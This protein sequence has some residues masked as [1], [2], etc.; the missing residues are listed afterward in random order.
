M[1][2]SS[3]NTYSAGVKGNKIGA[4]NYIQKLQKQL[5]NLSLKVGTELNMKKDNIAGAVTINPKLLEKMQNNP[6][7]EKKYTQMLQGI[8]RAESIVG[9]YYNS[10]G[11]VVERTSHWYMD[12]NG[13][14]VSFGHVRIENKLDKELR[15]QAD[16]NTKKFIEKTREKAR[17]KAEK[18]LSE[19]FL[20]TSSGEIYLNEMDMKPILQAIRVEFADKLVEKNQERTGVIYKSTISD[21]VS[22]GL[23]FIQEI[24]KQF[25]GTKFFVG[26]VSYGQTYGNSTDT[27][28]VINPNFLSKLGTDEATRKQFEEDVKFLNDFSQNFREQQLAQGREIINQGWFCDENGNWGGWCVSR[29]TKQSSVLQDMSDNAEKIRKEKMEERKIVEEKFKEH[30]GDC[31]KGFQVKWQ[32]EV[33]QEETEKVEPQEENTEVE[34]ESIGGKVGVNVGKTARKIEA[35]KTKTQLRAVIAEISG[36]MQEVKAG[37]EKGWCDESEMEKVNQLMAMAQ[38]KMG[39]VEDREATPEEENM[40]ALASLM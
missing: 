17:N 34:S 19:K 15:K 29:P 23:K 28:F 25:G 40:F 12:E 24:E 32:E 26:T 18:I 20:D 8:Q 10:I 30:F 31:F 38:N 37:I 14:L 2:I 27:N 3:V 35:A 7:A 6:N 13:N 9:S 22:A 33:E 1:V 11:N 16:E 4:D 5:K 39:Q 36:D 21:T